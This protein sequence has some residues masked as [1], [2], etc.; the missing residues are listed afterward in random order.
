MSE[1]P[2]RVASPQSEEFVPNPDLLLS[3]EEQLERHLAR[4]AYQEKPIP[5]FEDVPKLTITPVFNPTSAPD[6]EVYA[7]GR[8]PVSAQRRN[9]ALRSEWQPDDPTPVTAWR[10]VE[11]SMVEDGTGLVSSSV[12]HGNSVGD[13]E[14][15]NFRK[16]QASSHQRRM[17]SE[18]VATP[19][20]SF[21]TDPEQL[22]DIIK[23]L[24]FGVGE[25]RDSVVVQVRVDPDRLIT[26]KEPK[27]VEVFL[28]GGVAPE[29]YVAAYSMDA[30]VGKFEQEKAKDEEAKQEEL[31]RELVL[32]VGEAASV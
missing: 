6:G 4:M 22:V 10:I 21:S 7:R 3:D 32:P 19:L 20:I 23:R 18:D 25:G 1:Q 14:G 30:F 15:F 26:G 17:E 11:R 5:S 28:L 13:V 2:K 24:K 31:R 16:H 8:V 9:L 12:L 29:E 27:C